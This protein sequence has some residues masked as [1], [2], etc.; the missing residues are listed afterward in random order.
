MA[1]KFHRDML[2]AACGQGKKGEVQKV[3]NQIH[4]YMDMHH[5]RFGYIITEKELVMFRRRDEGGGWGRIDF[6]PKPIK[7]QAPKG[8]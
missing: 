1:G 5:N 6:S 4:D 7:I 2:I 8:V 3:M